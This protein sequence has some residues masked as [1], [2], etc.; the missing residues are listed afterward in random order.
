MPDGP[1]IDELLDAPVLAR[2][3]AFGR[4]HVHE[5]VFARDRAGDHAVLATIRPSGRSGRKWY[6]SFELYERST[7]RWTATGV[8]DG[9]VWPAAPDGPRPPTPGFELSTGMAGFGG[10]ETALAVTGGVVGTP[11]STLEMA[12]A[13]ERHL[14]EVDPATGAFTAVG[15][16]DDHAYRFTLTA[17]DEDGAVIDAIEFAAESEPVQLYHLSPVENRDSIRAH[18]L[19]PSRMGAAPG[20]AGSERPEV[21]GVYVF[22]DPGEAKWWAGTMGERH[23]S[24]L[25]LWQF[26]AQQAQLAA[27]PDGFDHLTGTVAPE[28]LRLRQTFTPEQLAEMAAG[29]PGPEVFDAVDGVNGAVILRFDDDA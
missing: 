24:G 25:D 13:L 5:R 3:A 8:G 2:G 16:C 17:R 27:G 1:P 20:L 19:D 9:E 4:P 23:R 10:A 14:V 7:G 21:T 6:W 15:L 26:T 28:A 12:T 22:D 11:V 29:G 18:G